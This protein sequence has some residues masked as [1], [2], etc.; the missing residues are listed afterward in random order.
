[1]DAHGHIPHLREVLLFLAAAGLVVPLLQRKISPVLGYLLLGGLIGPYGLGLIADEYPLVGQFVITEIEGVRALA[2]LGVVFLLFTIGLELSLSRLWTMRRLVFG[3]GSAQILVTGAAIGFIALG[4]DNPVGVAVLL[5]SSFALS[6]TAI[7][8]QLLVESRRLGTP[9]GRAAFSVLLMQDLAVVPILFA[10]GVIG[11]SASGSLAAGLGLAVGEAMVT[12]AVIYAAGRLLIR[13]LLRFVAKT[14]SRE[15]FMAVILLLSVGTAALTGV[16]GL[17]MA[18]GAFLAGLLIAET[19]YRHQV[20]VDIEPFKGLMLGL[21][22]M[23]VGMGIDLRTV[24][25]EP[26]WIIASVAGLLLLKALIN[27]GLCLLWGLPRHRALEAGLLLSQAGEF[28]FVV[29]G[30][31]MSLGLMPERTGQFMLIVASLT[32]LLTPGIATAARRIAAAMERRSL[33]SEAA[34]GD[35]AESEAEL[36]GHVI[37]AGFGRVGQTVAA[38]LDAEQIP[39][40]AVDTDPAIA[41]QK[42]AD[43]TPVRFGDASRLEVLTA[44][45]LDHAAAVV[46][47]I[48]ERERTKQLTADIRR[49]APQIPLY[50]RA[51]DTAHAERLRAAGATAAIPETVEGSFQLAARVLAGCGADEEVVARR[52]DL[53]RSA[54]ETG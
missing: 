46:V 1:M 32:M 48:G 30:L 50:V 47:T 44:A 22:F 5:G 19:E 51:R 6:S 12:I 26:F 18:L 21:F 28:A 40:V 10:I 23:S 45:R 34:T 43:G 33:A 42:R 13:P 20:E 36:E 2:E 27:T 53:E 39:Y 8:S 9:V 49:A 11:A 16:A 24:G 7:V 31:A 4:W 14:G 41:R 37:L 15:A 54:I 3:L 52:I 38:V 29:V 35:S 17:S 25:E